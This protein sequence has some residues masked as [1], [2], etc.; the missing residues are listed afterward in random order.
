M[1]ELNS[2]PLSFLPAD[3]DPASDLL[4]ALLEVSLSAV[5]LLRPVYG[6]GGEVAD[7]DLEYLNPAGQE[8]I[9]LAGRPHTTLLASFP[10]TANTGILD[11]YRRV[12]ETGEPG[13]YDVNYPFDGLDMYF[14]LSARRTGQQLVVSWSD[15]SQKDRSREL[16]AARADAELQRRRLEGLFMQAP[17]AIC[18]LGGPD[19]VY[20]LVNP[21][22]QQL[23]P[24]RQLLGL[25]ILEALPEIAGNA[26]YRTF[27]Q[28][29]ETGRSH[30]EEALLIPF[31][32]PATGELEN[33]Y[34][35]FIQQA[36]RNTGGQVDGVLVFAFEVTEQVRAR[37]ASEASAHQL[38]LITDAL[39]VLIGYLDKN[40]R[41]R[42]ANKAYTRWFNRS[43]ESMIGLSPRELAGE[44]AY[45]NVEPYIERALK[46]ERLDF[47]A[48]MPYRENFKRYTRTTFVPDIREEEVAGFYIMVTD[49]TEQVEARQ[50]LEESEQQAQAL[51]RDL[52]QANEELR[53][54]NQQLTRINID[55]DNFIYTASH[56]LKTPILNI[57]GLMEA[58]TDQL[59][60]EGVQSAEMQ[61]ITYLALDSV[62]RFKRTIDHLT[63]ITK[64]QKAHNPEASAINLAALLAEVLLDLGPAIQASQAQVLV[65]FSAVHTISFSE[66]NLRSIIYNLLSNAIKYQAPGRPPLVQVG[67]AEI[68]G[69]QVLSVQDNGL[70]MDL[71][72]NH[73]LFTM[74]NRL[75]DHVEGSGIGLY[76]VKKIIE[77]A[78]GRIEVESKLGEGSLFK[79][80]FPKETNR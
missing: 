49:I 33:R 76:M 32:H 9:R 74:F 40:Q 60:L 29:Y 24:G 66:K 11:F 27:R 47:E 46:G 50:A 2:P 73:K 53:L 52:A 71:S 5:C 79:V 14:Q 10:E 23:F 55:L 28:V 45:R 78:G 21:A 68:P 69:Y 25:P 13:R 72:G 77:N 56:D 1:P 54:A 63:D 35:K 39:P 61:R 3:S 7:F 15:T 48:F 4:Q 38:R 41:Y 44:Q 67:Y 62:Q 19:L 64:L 17:G 18:I 12:F 16:E 6:P 58:L 26:V 31:I 34:F 30:Q 57:E 70:G 22:Y 80:F 51:A 8:M 37:Q 42:F 36:R 20:E 75:H 65:G 43:V 59:S